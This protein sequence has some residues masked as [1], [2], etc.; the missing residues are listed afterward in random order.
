MLAVLPLL[1]NHYLRIYGHSKSN[2]DKF[3]NAR[4]NVLAIPALLLRAH[5]ASLDRTCSSLMPA[6]HRGHMIMK[7]AFVAS[8]VC[9]LPHLGQITTVFRVCLAG[10]RIIW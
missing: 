5:S 6:P 2:Y 4:V 3:R 7:V 9:F 1:V 8:T 10:R